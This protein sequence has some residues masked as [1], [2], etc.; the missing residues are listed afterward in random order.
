[1][2]SDD[3]K[4]NYHSYINQIKDVMDPVILKMRS[5]KDGKWRGSAWSGPIKQLI[6]YTKHLKLFAAVKWSS[7]PLIGQALVIAAGWYTKVPVWSIFATSAIFL[8]LIYYLFYVRR[9]I[10]KMATLGTAEFHVEALKAR[11]PTEYALWH[12]FL[13]KDDFTF[14][15]L[16]SVLNS[17][18]VPI[19][20]NTIESVLHY[21]I[22]RE[23]ALEETI[24]DQR[25]R[26]TEY[27]NIVDGLVSDLELSDNAIGY[28]VQ[29]ITE[30]NVNLYRMTNDV[31]DFH[32]L[33]FVTPFTIYEV[34]GNVLRK[35][36]DIGTSGGSLDSID[37]T[38]TQEFEYAA[39]TAARSKSRDVE[40]FVSNPYP[41]RSIVA[42]AMRM[43]NQKQWIWC[44]HF[45]ESDERALSLVLT[46]DIIESRQIRRLVH[47][48]CLILQK[49][50]I[51]EKE[52][53]Q[54]AAEQAN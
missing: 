33:R 1:M 8:F 37:M 23:E 13:Q 43:L 39:V 6:G 34:E 28:L 27:E 49:R 30:V 14:T 54:D 47:A 35:I 11:R 22:G 53:T 7:L 46:N 44:F 38:L 45:D 19:K 4:K 24:Q 48:F 26:I 20:D 17:Y 5:Q 12:T 10:D 9:Y 31:L 29:L 25:E 16:Y 42:F 2:N 40:A 36:Q 52:A 32:D 50:M 15:D 51:A 3:I 41:G 21:S 18:L